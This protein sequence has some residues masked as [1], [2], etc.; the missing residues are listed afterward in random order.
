MGLAQD[1]LISLGMT[2]IER[3]WVTN[4]EF[5]ALRH[6]LYE[7]YRELD[8]NGAAERLMY[9]VQRLPFRS[10]SESIIEKAFKEIPI[11]ETDPTGL[12]SE[13]NYEGEDRRGKRT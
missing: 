7:P 3:G 9:A 10:S 8:G 1:R 4:D 5:H 11:R 13:K 6:Y 2:Y 12:P